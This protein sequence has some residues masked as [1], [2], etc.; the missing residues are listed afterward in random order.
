MS[1][2][3]PSRRPTYDRLTVVPNQSGVG[4]VSGVDMRLPSRGVAKDVGGSMSMVIQA[5][6][7]GQSASFDKMRLVSAGNI[8][9]QQAFYDNEQEKYKNWLNGQSVRYTGRQIRR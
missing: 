3:Y 7:Q 8:S 5:P 9:R 2:S 1:Y 4:P 6:R